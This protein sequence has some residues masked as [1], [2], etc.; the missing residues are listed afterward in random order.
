LRL[1]VAHS[2]PGAGRAWCDALAARLPAAHVAIDPGTPDGAGPGGAPPGF[3]A[4][5][6]VGW[7]PPADLFARQPRLR[8]FFSSGAGVDHLL[9]HPGLPAALPLIRLEDAGM[10]ELMADYCLHELLR[11]AGRHDVYAAQQARARRPA[12]YAFLFFSLSTLRRTCSFLVMQCG[13]CFLQSWRW[14]SSS[15]YLTSKHLLQRRTTG[16]ASHHLQQS[17]TSVSCSWPEAAPASAAAAASPDP[18]PLACAPGPARLGPAHVPVS[19]APD[20]P[21]NDISL[22]PPDNN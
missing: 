15:Q 5:W 19:C 6:A 21:R 14:Q 18:P 1:L 16:E 11:I 3:E 9:R 8:G 12:L 4:D 2:E 10:A 7:G 13:L 22:I 20:R 17:L